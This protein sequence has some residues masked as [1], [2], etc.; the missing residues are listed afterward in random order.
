MGGALVG[1]AEECGCGARECTCGNTSR[2]REATA[3][4]TPTTATRLDIGTSVTPPPSSRPRTWHISATPLTADRHVHTS[5]KAASGRD[6]AHT[7]SVPYMGRID[8]SVTL[9][10]A[11]R[12]AARHHII[13]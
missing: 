9:T 11:W 5:H 13:S 3:F 8:T 4:A 1:T 2:D 12:V 10:A 7:R 6:T